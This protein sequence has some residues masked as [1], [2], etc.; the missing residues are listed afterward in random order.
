MERSFDWIVS[1]LGIMWARAAYVPLDQA[2]PDSRLRF[3]VEDSGAAALVAR[4]ALI[5]RLRVKARSVDPPRD[6]TAI[7][8]SASVALAP[9][10]PDS[11]AYVIYTSG[12]LSET[13]PEQFHSVTFNGRIAS[14]RVW[15]LLWGP[16][17]HFVEP[18]HISNQ[19]ATSTCSLNQKG[20]SG[21]LPSVQQVGETAQKRFLNR[22]S[23]AR[24][25]PGS[26]SFPIET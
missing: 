21:F 15:V 13:G 24:L 10:Q 5:D 22:R 2:W 9:I 17:V 14:L 25:S 16:L 7:R 18:R 3:A 11:L 1:A 8:V 6:A 20:L 23:G 4:A 12:S 19:L 26:P